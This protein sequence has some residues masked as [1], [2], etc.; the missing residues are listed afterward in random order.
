MTLLFCTY[1]LHQIALSKLN[2]IMQITAIR[3]E[4]P[5]LPDLPEQAWK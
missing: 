2:G 4:L 1:T 5:G 3:K